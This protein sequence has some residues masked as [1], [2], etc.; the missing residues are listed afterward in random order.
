MAQAE[1]TS[2]G[3]TSLNQREHGISEDLKE[4]EER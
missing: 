1:E 3:N 4:R 2:C